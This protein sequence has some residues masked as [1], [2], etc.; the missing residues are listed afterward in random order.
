MCTILTPVLVE[1]CADE[2]SW[3]QSDLWNVQKEVTM[4]A[5][6]PRSQVKKSQTWNAE[7]VFASSEAFDAEVQGILESLPAIKA[8][9]GRLGDGPD[10]FIAVMDAID[11]LSQRAAQDHINFLKTGSSKPPMEVFKIAGVD[12]TSTQPIEDAFEV[13]EDYIDRLESLTGK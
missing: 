6:L 3:K 4:P 12:M 10:T 8:F 5:A 13:M 1:Y 11:A 2:L 9:Q 7:S